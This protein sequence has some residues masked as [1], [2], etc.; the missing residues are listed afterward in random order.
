MCSFPIFATRLK[1]VTTSF[2]VDVNWTGIVGKIKINTLATVIDPPL[3]D[4]NSVVE[5]VKKK[6]NPS[7]LRK[8]SS[9]TKHF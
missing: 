3:V 7:L 8:F 2:S 4:F 5:Q 9:S 1:D 6:K